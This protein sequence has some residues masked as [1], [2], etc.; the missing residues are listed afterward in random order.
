M[1]PVLSGT[2]IYLDLNENGILD[3]GEPSQVSDDNGMYE[4]DGLAS[5]TYVVREQIPE[6]YQQTFPVDGVHRV[7]VGDSEVLEGLNFGNTKS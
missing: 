5:G 1:E 3:P 2:T 7:T 6:G 4:F